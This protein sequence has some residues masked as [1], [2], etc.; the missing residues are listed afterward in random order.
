MDISLITSLFRAEEHLA[1]YSAALLA[2]G[3][4]L[5]AAGLALEVVIVANDASPAERALIDRLAEQAESQGAVHPVILHV[6]RESLYASWN[7]GVTAA[8]SGCIGIWNVDDVRTADALIEG[9]RLIAGG[10]QV[11]DFPFTQRIRHRWMGMGWTTSRNY[12]A[13]YRPDIISPKAAFSPF[14]MFARTL[15]EQAGP[16]D[17]H[18]RIAGDFEWSARAA[19]RAAR[20]CPGTHNAGMFILHAGN[21]SASGNPLEWVEIDIV[22]MRHRQWDRLRPVDPDLLRENWLAWGS[23]GSDLPDAIADRMWGPGADARLL[24][25]QRGQ[26]RAARSRRLRALPRAIINRAGL[27]PLLARLGLVKP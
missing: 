8:S 26:R 1:A 25:W 4:Q 24:A 14:F 16:F 6:P 18:F 5:R 10:C 23:A 19:V 7:R 13:P 22:L 2:V 15:Y 20:Y 17:E 21:L 3:A 27:R 9:Q 11:V 12:P